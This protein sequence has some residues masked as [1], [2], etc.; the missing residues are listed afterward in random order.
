MYMAGEES[1]RGLRYSLSSG[2]YVGQ[3]TLLAVVD[4]RD[5]GLALRYEVVI[6][7]VVR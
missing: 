5:R 2:P 4:V 1:V 7:D 3:Q 6:V